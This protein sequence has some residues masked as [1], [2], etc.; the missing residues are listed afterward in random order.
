[1]A[2]IFVSHSAAD[3]ATVEYLKKNLT[4]W[5]YQS[6]FLAPDSVYGPTAGA[7]WRKDLYRGMTDAQLV[8]VLWSENFKESAWGAAEV[9]LADYLDKRIVPIL[10]DATPLGGL[11]ESRQAVD[12]RRDGTL[13]SADWPRSRHHGQSGHSS[14]RRC[15]S[16]RRVAR[17]H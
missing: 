13:D 5:G 14:R 9:V 17:R 7:W 2:K 6:F 16:R 4:Q 1:M 8:L 12:L 11:L 3:A 10:T 15:I